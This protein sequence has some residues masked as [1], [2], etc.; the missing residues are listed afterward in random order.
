MKK[1][2][3]ILAVL[4]LISCSLAPAFAN[5]APLSVREGVLRVY[6]EAYAISTNG[7]KQFV[8]AWI[9]SAFA[10]SKNADGSI[11]LVTNRH[12]VDSIYAD[13]EIAS[14]VGRGYVIE[15]EIYIVN[16]DADHMVQAEVI[17][18]SKKTDLALLRVRSLNN[19]DLLLKIWKGDPS[20]LVQATVYTAGFPGASDGIKK[21]T[22]YYQLRSDIDSVTL[23]D[24]KVTRIIDAGQTEFGEVIQHTAATNSG[25][26]GGPL[27]DEDGNV[28]G[29]NTWSSTEGEMTFW[30][31]SNRGLISF[32]E[33][34]SISYQ[35]GKRIH[36]TDPALIAI[37]AAVVL[38]IVIIVAAARQRKVNKEQNRQIEELLH[39]RF[40]THLTSIIA[41]K[42]TVH[43]EQKAL[44]KKEPSDSSSG[45]GSGRVLRCDHGALAGQSY[46]FKKSIV[47]GRDPQKCDVVFQKDIP[48]VS[49]VHCILRFN[50]ETVT[51]RDE[52]SSSGT[53]IDGKRIEPG[54]DIVF[55]RGHKLG[56]GSAN[57]QVFSLHSLH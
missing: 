50:G 16:D 18:I 10:V 53:Y 15:N 25:N 28:I 49:R 4:W 37:G 45:T 5:E 8:N 23:A 17:S 46:P 40:L 9:G 24:G 2:A 54:T 41:P 21:A 55:H 14:L 47:I 34:N 30:S 1:L 19:R 38:A 31:I 51:V 57:E 13:E 27:L 22:A 33:E 32:L 44:P 36:K 26:S 56:I 35:E 11:I 29:V 43:T 12:C 52:N 48:N 20:E 3:W 39:K 42:K 7:E 6:G